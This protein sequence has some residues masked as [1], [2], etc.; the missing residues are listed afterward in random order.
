MG[1]CLSSAGA[2][3]CWCWVSVWSFHSSVLVMTLLFVNSPNWGFGSC[4]HLLPIDS[5]WC[6]FLFTTSCGRSV[7]S[8][9]VFRVSC[10]TYSSCLQVFVEWVSIGPPTLPSSLSFPEVKY[11]WKN[12]KYIILWSLITNLKKKTWNITFSLSPMEISSVIK[13]PSNLAYWSLPLHSRKHGIMPQEES[14]LI[15]GI[16]LNWL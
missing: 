12:L 15:F 16:V 4:L 14:D 11:N 9:F 1:T 6:H 8:V 13:I 7:L 3:G 2:Q 10:N 5:F